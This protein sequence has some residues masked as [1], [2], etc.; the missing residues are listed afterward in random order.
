MCEHGLQRLHCMACSPHKFCTHGRYRTQ[1][2]ACRPDTPGSIFA[3]LA[4]TLA[5]GGG[6]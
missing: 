6:I 3:E 2:K 1:C 5:M 4:G